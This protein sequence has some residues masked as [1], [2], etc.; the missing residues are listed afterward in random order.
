MS[1][2]MDIE[3][4]AVDTGTEYGFHYMDFTVTLAHPQVCPG[5]QI[6]VYFSHAPGA[7]NG[8]NDYVYRGNFFQSDSSTLKLHYDYSLAYY[9]DKFAGYDDVYISAAIDNP[10]LFSYEDSAGNMVYPAAGHLSNEV[11]VYNNLKN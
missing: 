4:L 6:L 8:C 3:N 1:P 5:S 2:W 10:K 11:E 9:S 7:G